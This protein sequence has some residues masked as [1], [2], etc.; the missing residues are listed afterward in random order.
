MIQKCFKYK[1]FAYIEYTN[2]IDKVLLQI[3]FFFFNEFVII[4]KTVR[5]GKKIN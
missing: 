4:V 2:I 5:K 3:N 1:Y